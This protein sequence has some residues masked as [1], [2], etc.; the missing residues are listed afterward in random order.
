MKCQYCN[1]E[2]KKY[3]KTWFRC[4]NKKCKGINLLPD[5]LSSWWSSL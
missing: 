5:G 4:D 2:M 1:K 3:N